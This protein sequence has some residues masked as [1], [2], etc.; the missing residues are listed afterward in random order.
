[1]NFPHKRQK[2]GNSPLLSSFITFTDVV[3]MSGLHTAWD[4]GSFRMTIA[5]IHVDVQF[6]TLGNQETYIDFVFFQHSY[7]FHITKWSR[8][9]INRF[10]DAFVQHY[11]KGEN[12]KYGEEQ[13]DIVTGEP[14]VVCRTVEQR[15][16]C[17]RQAIRDVMETLGK[18]FIVHGRGVLDYA[19]WYRENK[20]DES[21]YDLYITRICCHCIVHSNFIAPNADYTIVRFS[22]TT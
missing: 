20:Q 12:N 4:E 9:G 15:K 6:R 13:A 22:S 7:S 5:D 11:G 10:C 3:D 19:V 21:N 18:I 14:T 8:S 16:N 1:M 17:L 2:I